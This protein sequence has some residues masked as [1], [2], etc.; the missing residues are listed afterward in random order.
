MIMII[1]KTKTEMRVK[2]DHE[3]RKRRQTYRRK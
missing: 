3:L 1:S 2:D